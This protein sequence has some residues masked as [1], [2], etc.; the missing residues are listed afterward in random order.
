MQRE[1][2]KKPEV[3][4]FSNSVAVENSH[5]LKTNDDDLFKSFHFIIRIAM[6]ITMVTIHARPQYVRARDHA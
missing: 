4:Y 6:F 5:A 2:E 1:T 3:L